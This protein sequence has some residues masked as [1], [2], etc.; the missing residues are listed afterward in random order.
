MMAELWTSLF[1]EVFKQKNPMFLILYKTLCYLTRKPSSKIFCWVLPV[2][3]EFCDQDS[4][5]SILFR[6]IILDRLRISVWAGCL[7][8]NAINHR[9]WQIQQIRHISDGLWRS[10]VS[11]GFR[12]CLGAATSSWHQ[13]PYYL[14]LE[15]PPL[16]AI[17]KILRSRGG[18]FLKTQLRDRFQNCNRFL[19]AADNRILDFL[20]KV[21]L[22]FSRKAHLMIMM[23]FDRRPQIPEQVFEI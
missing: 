2:W 9:E 19:S 23:E 11:T 16:G 15:S 4:P 8:R 20:L 5:A 18:G 12:Q 1:C 10:V 22:G 14:V 21:P 6:S 13:P 17:L 3:D 7:V